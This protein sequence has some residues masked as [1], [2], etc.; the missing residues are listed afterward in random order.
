MPAI[1]VETGFIDSEKDIQV[2][3]SD[4]GQTAIAKAIAEA[5]LEYDDMPPIEKTV[6]EVQEN[7]DSEEAGAFGTGREP[8]QT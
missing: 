8:E 3:S 7:E 1:L 6:K 4:R 5:V 2:I